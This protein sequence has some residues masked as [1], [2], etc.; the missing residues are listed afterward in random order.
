M[1]RLKGKRGILA[2]NHPSIAAIYGIEEGAIDVF[3]LVL[4]EIPDTR[5]R[6]R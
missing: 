1:A 6:W 4:F 2:L 5:F 3:G